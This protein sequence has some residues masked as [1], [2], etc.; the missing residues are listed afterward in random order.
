MSDKFESSNRRRTALFSRRLSWGYV[1]IVLD[2][3][4]YD[5]SCTTRTTIILMIVCHAKQIVDTDCDVMTSDWTRQR[6]VNIIPEPLK[7]AVSSVEWHGRYIDLKLNCCGS[8]ADLDI[9]ANALFQ[10]YGK[11]VTY[12]VVYYLQIYTGKSSSHSHCDC[13]RS[14]RIL[15]TE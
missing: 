14:L 11:H 3:I 12:R 15:F 10:L 5:C 9:H 2:V 7:R 13:M 6:G 1:G 4:S 8:G